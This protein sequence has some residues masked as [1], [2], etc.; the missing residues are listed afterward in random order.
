MKTT[1]FLFLIIG[2]IFPTQSSEQALPLALVGL[3]HV[4]VGWVFESEKRGEI[5]IVGIVEV[6]TQ[7]ALRLSK[8]FGFSMSKVYPNIQAMMKKVKPKAVAAFGSI[9]EHLEVVETMAPLGVHV[10]V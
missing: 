7:L 3:T 8:Q 9:Y 6:N 5:E 2:F 4:H 10:M 1:V